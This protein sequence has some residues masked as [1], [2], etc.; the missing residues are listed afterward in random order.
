MGTKQQRGEEHPPRRVSGIG[1]AVKGLL[2]A[3]AFQPLA[4]QLTGP[5]H[6][7]RGFAGAA[8][9]RLFVMPTQLHLAENTLPLHLLLERLQRLIDVIVTHENLHL[10]ADSFRRTPADQ[11]RKNDPLQG[12][13]ARG[14]AL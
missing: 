11:G 5:A 13:P 12:I 6:G 2:E 8:L 1:F 3:L 4:F 9:R 14:M 7:F 10:A